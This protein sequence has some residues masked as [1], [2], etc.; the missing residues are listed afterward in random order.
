MIAGM[1]RTQ[2]EE[3]VAEGMRTADAVWA[4]FRHV[5]PK[6]GEFAAAIA[7]RNPGVDAT[8][9]TGVV[10]GWLSEYRTLPADKAPVRY[11]AYLGFEVLQ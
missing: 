11:R 5:T 8:L 4:R 3:V 2:A 9:W 1:T 7:E 6:P 10:D